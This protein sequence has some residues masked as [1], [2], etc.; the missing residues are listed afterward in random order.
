MWGVQVGIKSCG[1]TNIA[2]ENHAGE[3][4]HWVL[5]DFKGDL[6]GNMVTVYISLPVI[7]YFLNV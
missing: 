4:L 5:V 7:R 6:E 3:L 2:N 1:L